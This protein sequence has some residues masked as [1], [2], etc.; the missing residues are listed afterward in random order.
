MANRA[1]SCARARPPPNHARARGPRLIMGIH[2]R[3]PPIPPQIERSKYVDR[4][5]EAARTKLKQ[6]DERQAQHDAEHRGER[7]YAEDWWLK[8]EHHP[9]R[10]TAL[11]MDAPTET[12]FDVPVQQRNA[13]DPVKSLDTAKKWS[14]KITGLMIAGVGMLAF[15]TRDGLGSGPNLSCTVLY[16]GLLHV[17]S[18][19]GAL[20]CKLNVLLDNTAADNKNNEMIYFLGWLVLIDI[21]DEASFFCMIKGHTYSVRFCCSNERR[22]VRHL[23]LPVAAYLM[24]ARLESRNCSES[25][26]PFAP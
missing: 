22:R 6:I 16:L 19:V 25:T 12:Q 23:R 13:Y 14:S 15:V 2:W 9:T 26:R 1:L 21:V 3:L 24:P 5:D 7:D 10:V 17:V 4:T 8:G 18:K 11:S 20:G